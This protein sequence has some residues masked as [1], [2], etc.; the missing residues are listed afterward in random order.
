M[1]VRTPCNCHFFDFVLRFWPS[2]QIQDARMGMILKTSGYYHY[3][4]NYVWKIIKVTLTKRFAVVCETWN[5]WLNSKSAFFAGRYKTGETDKGMRKSGW[6][7]GCL[8]CPWVVSG[9]D[10]SRRPSAQEL[11][12]YC[13]PGTVFVYVPS[14]TGSYFHRCIFVSGFPD[15]SR[16]QFPLRCSFRFDFYH[17]RWIF[18]QSTFWATGL[19]GR[20]W[21]IYLPAVRFLDRDQ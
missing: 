21:E 6:V 19:F 1:F 7:R 12:P 10:L 15:W 13:V 2:K 14:R 3:L 11:P 4:K 18:Q 20:K 8:P 5:T 17:C 9:C 16:L